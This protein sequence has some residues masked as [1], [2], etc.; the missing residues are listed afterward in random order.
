M[1]PIEQHFFNVMLMV[2][3]VLALIVAISLCYIAAP[4]G[5]HARPGWGPL[6]PAWLGWLIMEAP[7]PILFAFFFLH[8]SRFQVSLAWLFFLMWEAHYVHRAFFFPFR[9][10]ASRKTMPVVVAAMGV[11]FNLFNGYLNGRWLG[12]HASAYAPNWLASPAFIIGSLCFLTGF[13]INRHADRVLFRLRTPGSQHYAIPYGGLYQWIS[14]PNYFGE[15]LAWAGFAL[16]TL[17][18]PALFFAVWTA[19][20]LMPRA[21]TH[22]QWY[23]KQF[24]D[25]PPNR[26]AILPFL[27]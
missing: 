23:K 24:S 21:F 22:H 7:S 1:S 11:F 18:P 10:R 9:M 12:L 2:G 16:A 26:K 13:A 3:Y 14:C 15:L 4:Y 20:N 17:S 25:Y 8:A 19:A 27:L 5:R 6:M